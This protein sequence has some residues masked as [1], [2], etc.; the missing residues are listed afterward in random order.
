[1]TTLSVDKVSVQLGPRPA[2]TDVSLS[3]KG[4]TSLD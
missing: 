3:L 4:V 1:M 2:L